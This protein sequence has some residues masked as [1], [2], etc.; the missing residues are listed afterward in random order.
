MLH[1]FK[2]AL[3]SSADERTLLKTDER[4][5]KIDTQISS[6][7]QVTSVKKH[8]EENERA[9]SALSYS[10]RTVGN[11]FR[12]AATLVENS[13][14]SQE[15]YDCSNA[16]VLG[17]EK[18]PNPRLSHANRVLRSFC[19]TVR[20]LRIQLAKAVDTL[21]KKCYY[22]SKL[23]SLQQAKSAQSS[24]LNAHEMSAQRLHRNEK[25]Y[26][27]ATTELETLTAE[28]ESGLADAEMRLS[29]VLAS[30][31]RA[32]VELQVNNFR[33]QPLESVVVDQLPEVED[34]YSERETDG[35]SFEASSGSQF[36]S[37]FCE[38]LESA[39]E[40]NTFL[41]CPSMIDGGD[42]A[43]F[44]TADDDDSCV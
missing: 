28:L 23:R 6:L 1:K 19:E 34:G 25:K 36:D 37:G 2:V 35:S 10:I 27:D 12:E 41:P 42:D 33:S 29:K 38:D 39:S 22:A 21:R 44:D 16:L 11:A 18:L 15:L 17:G 13:V 3:C 8:V 5:T 20:Q 30:A 40:V 9:W 43:G 26:E 4:L 14:A 7:M 24:N 31:V 32:F